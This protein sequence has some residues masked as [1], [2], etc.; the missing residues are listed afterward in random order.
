MLRVGIPTAN[1]GYNLHDRSWGVALI[2][3]LAIVSVELRK[4]RKVRITR[5]RFFDGLAVKDISISGQLDAMFSDP[6]PEVTHEGLRVRAG[7][8]AH[9]RMPE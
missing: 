7:S 6:I 1:L 2:S 4:L 8:F 3:V 9:Q 5:E